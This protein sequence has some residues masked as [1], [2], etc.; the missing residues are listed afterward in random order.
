[1]YG[2]IKFT[3]F[4]LKKYILQCTPNKR[5][6]NGAWK[7]PIRAAV[8]CIGKCVSFEVWYEKGLLNSQTEAFSRLSS[9]GK[10]AVPVDAD[11]PEYPLHSDQPYAIPN[12]LNGMDS[13]NEA[14][15][16]I[17][18]PLRHSIRIPTLGYTY[19]KVLTNSVAQCRLVL[20]RGKVFHLRLSKIMFCTASS[21]DLYKS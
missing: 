15:A 17:T 14:L 8:L 6:Y 7:S 1:M 11:I 18:N 3:G 13:L 9:L 10:T 21:T 5:R 4:I 2:Q 20:A 19:R 16:A 12:E